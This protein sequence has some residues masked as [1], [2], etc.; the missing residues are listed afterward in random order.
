ML[1]K[2]HR[3][4]PALNIASHPAFAQQADTG[5]NTKSRLK[6]TTFPKKSRDEYTFGI[7]LEYFPAFRVKGNV[8]MPWKS[9]A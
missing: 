1:Y 7:R 2:T 8:R 5:S 3:N 4:P 6:Y 9:A